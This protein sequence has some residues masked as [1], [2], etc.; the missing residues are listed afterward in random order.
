VAFQ[1]AGIPMP[2]RT[3][4]PQEAANEAWKFTTQN[5]GRSILINY[6]DPL[7]WAP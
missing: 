7:E 6:F 1:K 2:F 3:A 5:E 4:T